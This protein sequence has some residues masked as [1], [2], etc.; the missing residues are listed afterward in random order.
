MF[1][2]VNLPFTFSLTCLDASVATIDQDVSAGGEARG[3]RS[4][5]DGAV[6]ELVHVTKAAH[7]GA[8]L[9]FREEALE[10]TVQ[11]S[12]HVTGRDGVDTNAEGGPLNSERAREVENTGLGGVVRVL[13][14]GEVDDVGGHGRDVHD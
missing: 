2:I 11:G 1:Y 4:Q 7:R 14:L 6:G 5:V 9:P 8:A 12:V 13:R 3:R 10:R